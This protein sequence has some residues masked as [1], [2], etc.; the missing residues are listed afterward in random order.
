MSSIPDP[1]LPDV[2][3]A[4]LSDDE[5]AALLRDLGAC[6]EVLS[7]RVRG[8]LPGGAPTLALGDVQSS[9]AGGAAAAVQITYRFGGA[10]WIDT[11]TRRDGGTRVVRIGRG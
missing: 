8:A 2:H 7:L 5:L 6:A 4:M 9:L 3:E 11:L 1:P 10:T